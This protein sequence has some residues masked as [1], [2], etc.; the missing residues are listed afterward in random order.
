MG[1]VAP[2]CVGLPGAELELMLP[3]LAGGLCL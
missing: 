2:Q 1:L 3:A